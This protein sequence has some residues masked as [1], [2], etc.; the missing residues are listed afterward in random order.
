MG[1]EGGKV[2]MGGSKGADGRERGWHFFLMWLNC[3]CLRL[4][5]RC[6]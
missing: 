1:W 2:G 6:G 5:P 3:I 4:G